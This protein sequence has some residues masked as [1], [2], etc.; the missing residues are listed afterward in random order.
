MASGQIGLRFDPELATGKIRVKMKKQHGKRRFKADRSEPGLVF[1]TFTSRNASFNSVPGE[2]LS[3][4]FKTPGST[5]VGTRSRVW[6]D[7]ALTFFVDAEGDVLRYR[8][9]DGEIEIEAD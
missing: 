5:P 4:K 6:I 3:V 8:F 1:V 7:P 9:E 2:L